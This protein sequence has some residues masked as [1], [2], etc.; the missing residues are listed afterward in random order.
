MKFVVCKDYDEMS[1]WAA[2]VVRKIVNEK[3]NAVLGLATGSTPVGMYHRLA[4]LC[5]AGEIDFSEVK[6][7]NLDEYYPIDPSN[8]QSYR[9]FMNQNL[10]NHINIKPENAHVPNGSA[11]DANAEGKRYDKMI[12][13][14]GGLDF[15][16]LGSGVNGHIGFN[17]PDDALVAGTHLTALTENTIEVNSRFFE[18][19]EDVPR[20]AITMGMAPILKARK[21]LIMISGV[22]K[23]PILNALASGKI[24]TQI[25]A[26]M[27]Q[28]HNDVTVVTDEATAA[29]M[30]ESF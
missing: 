21:I 18:K 26:T 2:E 29:L 17:E 8:D 4:E 7:F 16:F 6:T 28:M 10:H 14:A 1:Q 12:E 25:P 19:K 9:Y 11:E 27:L 23:V 22:N 13:E 15:Q 24:T 30:T 5:K 20:H 3:P